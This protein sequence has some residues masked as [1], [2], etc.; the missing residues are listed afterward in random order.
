MAKESQVGKWRA[1]PPDQIKAEDLSLKIIVL[2]QVRTINY[3]SANIFSN[4]ES[5]SNGLLNLRGALVA[6]D[7]TIN[8]ADR[9]IENYKKSDF[10]KWT[11][12][13]SDYVSSDNNSLKIKFFD[14]CMAWY[15]KLVRSL[16]V[17]DLLPAGTNVVNGKRYGS[18]VEYSFDRGFIDS[19]TGD[20]IDDMGMGKEKNNAAT[21]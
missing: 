3:I 19:E 21:D 10:E 15:F 9:G 14:N 2:I 18:K 5:V 1:I 17:F 16:L 20:V 8:G 4:Y 12:A 7:R 6:L 13:H 11:T